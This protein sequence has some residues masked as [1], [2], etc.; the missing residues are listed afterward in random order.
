MDLLRFMFITGVCVFELCK[1][2]V[3]RDGR[4][5]SWIVL[6]STKLRKLKIV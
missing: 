3:I 2:N 6:F 5:V 1:E 4:C